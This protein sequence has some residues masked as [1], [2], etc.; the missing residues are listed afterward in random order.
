M[1][2]CHALLR[3]GEVATLLRQHLRLPFE[4]DPEGGRGVVALLHTKT[5]T[6][7]AKIQSVLLTDG[8]LLELLTRVFGALPARR[9]LCAGGKKAFDRKFTAIDR[10][11]QVGHLFTPACLRGG[12]TFECFE[13]TG[14]L[15]EVQLRGRW[16]AQKSMLHYLQQGLAT[17]AWATLEPD[18]RQNIFGLASCA[19]LLVPAARAISQHE[20]CQEEK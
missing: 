14:N 15:G 5:S 10:Q 12:G 9:P 6:R 3:P 11:L 8:L 16:D 1:L 18:V 20:R 4:F 2:A 13:R 17:T 7:A 19:P